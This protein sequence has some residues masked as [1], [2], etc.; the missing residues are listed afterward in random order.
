MLA[1]VVAI[2]AIFLIYLY[3]NPSPN[4]G[5]GGN[6]GTA[7]VAYSGFLCS[8][9]Y[10]SIITGNLT[11]AIGENVGSNWN[12][13]YFAFVP[14]GTKINNGIPNVSFAQPNA[15]YINNMNSST[16]TTVNL[17]VAKPNTLT[18]DQRVIGSVWA[19][20]TINGTTQIS[21]AQIATIN[22]KAS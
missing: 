3:Y 5:W 10:L 15:V 2:F 13:V 9:P 21:Y 12:N 1:I 16:T 14:Q 7:C 4:P 8:N 17:A 18:K 22:I 20:Y 6:I 11:I 19:K